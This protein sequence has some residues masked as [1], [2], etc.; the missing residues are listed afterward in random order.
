MQ[1]GDILKLSKEGLDHI[2][3]YNEKGRERAKQWRFEYSCRTRRDLD[4]VSVKKL[5]KGYYRSYQKSFLEKV[6]DE[7]K[8]HTD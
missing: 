8:K 6:K 7:S 5:P 3:K 2:Y 1:R 4:C